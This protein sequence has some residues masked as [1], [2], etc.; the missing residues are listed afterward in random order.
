MR[1]ID[2]SET[3][4]KVIYNDCEFL[5]EKDDLHLLDG[6]TS[7]FSTN[8]YIS[9][10]VNKKKE[11]LHRLIMQP[12]EDQ[13]VDHKHRNKNDNRRRFLRICEKFQ[14]QANR[15]GF[16]VT[17]KYKGV[18]FQKRYGTF[19]ARVYFKGEQIDLGSFDSEEDA[20]L[21]Y[22]RKVK[23]LLGEYAYLNPI[24]DDGRELKP[25]KPK[26]YYFCKRSKKYIVQFRHVG[27]NIYGGCSKT[28]EGAIKLRDKKLQEL[29]A[30]L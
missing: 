29:G 19:N 5:I 14:N 25:N 1:V 21:A 22:N 23:E 13:E 9:V 18:R 24:E 6:F 10:R 12:S 20:G 4:V 27:K 28:E 2:L 30:F 11:Y 26:G 8:G 3:D 7:I 17:S 15:K 16:G